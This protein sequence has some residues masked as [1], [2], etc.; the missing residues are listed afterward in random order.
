MFR[1]A[2]YIYVMFRHVNF[3]L[4]LLLRVLYFY[5]IYLHAYVTVYIYLL[6]NRFSLHYYSIYW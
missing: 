4:R 2:E 5:T 3:C 6:V 1:S